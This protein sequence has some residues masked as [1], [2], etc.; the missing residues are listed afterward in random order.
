ME[1]IDKIT[2]AV[3]QKWA[4]DDFYASNT[5][6]LG[7]DIGA[8]GIG[9][10]IR[11]G[12]ELVY[13][14]TL[15]VDLPA[16][17]AL[18]ARRQLR[19][20]RHAR[21]NYRRRMRRL[22][23]LFSRHNL[24]WVSDEVCHRSDPFLLRYRAITGTLASKE[25]LTLCIRSCVALR[26]YDFFALSRDAGGEYPWGDSNALVDA[27]KWVRAEYVNEEMKDYL[28][29]LSTELVFK[30]K[31]LEDDSLDRWINLVNERFSCAEKEGIPAMLCQYAR[32]H[33]KGSHRARGHNYPRSHVE[34]HLREIL[35]RHK[36]LIDGY[37]AF[38]ESL[39]LPCNS[40]KN[41]EAAI[42]HYNRKTKDEAERHY[43]SKVK[44][45]PYSSWSELNLPLERCGVN[46]DKDIIAWKLVDFLS[47]RHFEFQQGK[48]SLMP[49]AGVKALW[50]AVQSGGRIGEV[51]K[52][53]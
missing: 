42:F 26:G 11:K 19:A 16:A 9:V 36:H 22:K 52:V 1:K 28:L 39:F 48:R 51:S 50:D 45:C 13:C 3:A 49:V 2:A 20:A 41:K 27:E 40:R 29:S 10:A 17:K 8:E 44:R 33:N 24:P 5:V 30:N 12:Q 6:S 23:E 4:E 53:A 37:D 47:V 7:L 14:Q 15:L 25:A 18:A 35:E 32:S 46:G 38:V 21:K 34:S 43:Q 31:E